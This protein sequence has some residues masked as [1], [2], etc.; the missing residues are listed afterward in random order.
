MGIGERRMRPQMGE[1]AKVNLRAGQEDRRGRA[2]EQ[3]DGFGPSV[4]YR[5]TAEEFI[6]RT[7]KARPANGKG[8][9]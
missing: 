2:Q 1:L 4:Q 9:P 8:E 7:Q 3:L 5:A 6:E